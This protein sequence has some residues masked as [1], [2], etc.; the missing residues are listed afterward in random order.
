[1]KNQ[2]RDTKSLQRCTCNECPTEVNAHF[3]VACSVTCPLNGSE[4]VG[5]LVLI[6][7]LTA[8]VVSIKLF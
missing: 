3:A 1:M 5:D 2:L 6:P 4:A 7:D 8:S